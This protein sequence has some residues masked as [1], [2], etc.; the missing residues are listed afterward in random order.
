LVGDEIDES[1][2]LNCTHY[3]RFLPADW[4]E[5]VKN[6][7][8]VKTRINVKCPECPGSKS[9]K[10]LCTTP[11]MAK[12]FIATSEEKCGKHH[13]EK[14]YRLSPFVINVGHSDQDLTS[15]DKIQPQQTS[16][17]TRKEQK[18]STKSST[19]TSKENRLFQRASNV[20]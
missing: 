1:K 15:K 7:N 5:I 12:L 18:T 3:G 4:V 19:K 2:K 16:S 6:P 11:P 10:T 14:E 17:L 8:Y 20:C 9:G 13:S